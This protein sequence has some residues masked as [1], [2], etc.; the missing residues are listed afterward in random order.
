MK[1]QI[2]VHAIKQSLG[3][4][5]I[6]SQINALRNALAI[7]SSENRRENEEKRSC[8]QALI[9]SPMKASSD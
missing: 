2:I 8:M 3:R 6:T 9:S 7:A 1:K 4:N 5:V